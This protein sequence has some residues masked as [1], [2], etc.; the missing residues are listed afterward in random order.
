M[1]SLCKEPNL[2]IT[3]SGH[4]V[5][6]LLVAVNRKSGVADYLP[7]IVWDEDAVACERSL[8]TSSLVHVLGRL[9]SRNYEKPG[10]SRH[11]AIEVISSKITF[12][13]AA[14]AGGHKNANMILLMG[15]LC[16]E[17][18]LRA[19][20]AGKMISDLIVAV[21]RKTGGTDYLPVICWNKDAESCGQHLYTGALVHVKG[22]LTSRNYERA[23]GSRHVAIEVSAQEIEFL[24]GAARREGRDP[25]DTDLQDRTRGEMASRA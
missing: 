7:V 25:R 9:S 14:R 20:S 2:R 4:H 18:S 17:P 5:C 16:R 12:L 23:D 21:D 6:D 11:V 8:K 13:S 15:N 1:G 10:G 19:T 22:I 3:P 24:G